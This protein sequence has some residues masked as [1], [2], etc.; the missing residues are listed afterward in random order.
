MDL[1][2]KV[3]NSNEQKYALNRWDSQFY[4]NEQFTWPRDCRLCYSLI[5]DLLNLGE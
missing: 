2:Q 1:A 4:S 3:N 5:Y